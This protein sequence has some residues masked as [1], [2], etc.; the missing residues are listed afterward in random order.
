MGQTPSTEQ[1]IRCS[2]CD[3]EGATPVEIEIGRRRL[4]KDLCEPH[5]AELLSNARRRGR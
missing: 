1:E 2:V 3:E 4:E 5:L